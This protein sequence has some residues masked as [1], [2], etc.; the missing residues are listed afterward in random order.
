MKYLLR[1]IL[2]VICRRSKTECT[3]VLIKDNYEQ[4]RHLNHDLQK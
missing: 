1:N 4:K 3:A 2:L